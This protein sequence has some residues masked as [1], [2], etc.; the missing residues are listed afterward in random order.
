MQRTD[1]LWPALTHLQ[2][3]G[4]GFSVFNTHARSPG[5]LRSLSTC[6]S[7]GGYAVMPLL[8]RELREL[9]LS[10][11]S[12]DVAPLLTLVRC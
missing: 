7:S 9:D 3:T 4:C 6:D 8:V 1:V 10:R 11:S 2:L 5:R 12:L